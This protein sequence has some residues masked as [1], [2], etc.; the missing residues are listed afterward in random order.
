MKAKSVL[1]TNWPDFMIVGAGKSGTTSLYRYLA[2]HEDIFMPHM[3]ETWFFHLI[4]NEN[5]EILNFLPNVP[6]NLLSYL[7]LFAD[8][9]DG[10]KCGD[11]TPSYLYYHDLAIP[12]IKEYHPAPEE[13][14]IIVILRE[15]I[16]KII[17][18]YNFVHL[19]GLDPEKLN[20]ADSI[21]F[22]KERRLKNQTLAD[23]FYV[24]TTLYY[25]SLKA[26]F[27]NFNHVKILLYDDLVDKPL[28]LIRDLYEFIGVDSSHTPDSLGRKFNNSVR[29]EV[30]KNMFSKLILENRG[31]A[32]KF[33][34]TNLKSKVK[35][36]FLKNEFE[37]ETIDHLKK[38]FKPEVEKLQTLIKLD[39]SQWL[40]KY[41]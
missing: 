20:F 13:L 10:Q 28:E 21:K 19:H 40:K 36:R 33:L 8:A 16:S 23:L 3:K 31:A 7:G 12:N 4:D 38:V 32:F 37:G 6:T 41:D 34:P 25:N 17:S 18:Q 24:H 1:E 14:R 30:P 9:Q 5:K 35:E 29:K 2:E 22:E 39:L 15:P 27:D 11:V 26:Y